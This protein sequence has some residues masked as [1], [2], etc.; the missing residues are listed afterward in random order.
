MCRKINSSTSL[1]G[2]FLWTSQREEE[3]NVMQALRVS[4]LEAVSRTVTFTPRQHLSDEQHRP[5][6]QQ[7]TES[8]K[9]DSTNAIKTSK[10]L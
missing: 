5:N 1:R 9:Q 8:E 10:G 6:V 7:C 3:K 4:K 2:P